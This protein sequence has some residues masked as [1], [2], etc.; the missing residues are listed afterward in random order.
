MIVESVKILR[1]VFLILGTLEPTAETE[2]VAIEDA[3]GGVSGS[4]LSSPL[5]SVFTLR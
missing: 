1:P 4:A 3:G 5:S 2:T